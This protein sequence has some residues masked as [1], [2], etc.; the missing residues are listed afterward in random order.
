METD[1]SL[2]SGEFT[3]NVK[4]SVINGPGIKSE[5]T[6]EKPY[7]VMIRETDIKAAG[8]SFDYTFEPHSITALVCA[9]S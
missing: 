6:E 1:I 2:I 9:V 5:N 7:Q 3:G 4:A 8:K